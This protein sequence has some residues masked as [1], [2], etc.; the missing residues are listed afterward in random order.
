[1]QQIPQ[2]EH[3]DAANGDLRV[4]GVAASGPQDERGEPGHPPQNR[5]HECDQ[6]VPELGGS[7]HGALSLRDG[8]S[9]LR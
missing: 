6:R 7:G 1:M 8:L 9:Q 5:G 2:T 3:A 4:V